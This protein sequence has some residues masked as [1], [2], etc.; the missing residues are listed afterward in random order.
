MGK[1]VLRGLALVAVLGVFGAAASGGFTDVEPPAAPN[2]VEVTTRASRASSLEGS[3]KAAA[4]QAPP[5]P[6]AEEAPP[7]PAPPADEAPPATAPPV[8]KAPTSPAG[9]F[10]VADAVGPSVSI[11]SAP[12]VAYADKPQLS[13]PTHEGLPVVFLVLEENGP[14]LKV[15]VSSRP[16]NLVAWV[17]RAEVALRTV[18]N[19]VLVE[20]GARRVTVFQGSEVLLQETVAVGTNRTP[21]PLGTFFVDGFVPLSPDTGPYGA[22]QVS[23]AG[24]S[25]VLQSFGGGVGQIAMHGTN[26][27]DLLGQPVSN[28]CVRMGNDAILRMAQLAPLGTPV[29]IVA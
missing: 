27:P 17:R 8:E 14:W 1:W 22:A 26:N 19:R 21:T 13:N 2:A 5:A 12:D 23:V 4:V 6:P 15:R 7:T 29:D 20:V 9:P 25:D 16:N 24:F 28:G 11:F 3:W 10:L 18:P